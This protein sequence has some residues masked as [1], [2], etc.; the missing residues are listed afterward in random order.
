MANL[1]EIIGTEQ[2]NQEITTPEPPLLVDY[3]ATWC[4]PCRAMAPVMENIAS[5][6]EGRLRVAKV[7]FDVPEN[8]D[9]TSERKI[10]SIPT[11]ELFAQG[12]VIG[13]IVGFMPEQR[14]AETL[15]AE[16]LKLS[17]Q[18]DSENLGDK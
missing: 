18:K 8:R 10:Y 11:L 7:D 5:R 2:F 9:I 14:L 1:I 12:E 13:R 17:N 6:F 3:C 15:D 16:L 4:G